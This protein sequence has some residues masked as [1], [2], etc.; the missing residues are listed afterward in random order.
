MPTSIQVIQIFYQI[1]S[2]Y[3]AHTREFRVH[4][5]LYSSFYYADNIYIHNINNQFYIKFYKLYRNEL[6]LSHPKY[7]QYPVQLIESKSDFTKFCSTEHKARAV[8]FK[9]L[10]SN[11]L[12]KLVR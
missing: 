11:Y 9:I 8:F 3:S 6:N 12:A 7:C 5:S 2:N 10:S 1:S 4:S